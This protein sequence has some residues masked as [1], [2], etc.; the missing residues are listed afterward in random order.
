MRFTFFALLSAG[1]IGSVNALPAAAPRGIYN[2]SL[3]KDAAD[4]LWIATV[5]DSTGAVNWTYGGLADSAAVQKIADERLA[6]RSALEAQDG[7]PSCNGYSAGNLSDVA[8]AE[9]GLATFFQNMSLWQKQV[10]Y[11]IGGTIAYCCDYA[12][13]NAFTTQTYTG[14]FNDMVA[15]SNT[16]G[17]TNAG[18]Y[19][20]PSNYN[21]FGRTDSND[22]FC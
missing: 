12:P 11:K 21:S 2:F 5:D 3:P 19:S 20:H 18:W 1:A 7:G 15:V 22:S 10:S 17:G 14:Y 6:S 16:C 13:D 4:G 9:N 8:N